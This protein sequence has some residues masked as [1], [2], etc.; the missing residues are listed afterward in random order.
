M[1]CVLPE[2]RGPKDDGGILF[3]GQDDTG[4]TYQGLYWHG[5]V[6]TTKVTSCRRDEDVQ[7]FLVDL[8]SSFF[9]SNHM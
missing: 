5:E 3:A 7:E 9:L 2:C 1:G 6:Y 4:G 8:L